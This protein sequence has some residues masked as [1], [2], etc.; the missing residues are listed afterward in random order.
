M[1]FNSNKKYV[2]APSAGGFQITKMSDSDGDFYRASFSNS[3]STSNSWYWI[4]YK[5]YAFTAGSNYRIRAKFRIIE[6]ENVDSLGLRHA[7]VS[8]DYWTSDLK[9]V[10][11]ISSSLNTW[12]EYS[13][14]RVINSS[15]TNSSG[16]SYDASQIG[17]AHV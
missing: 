8:N 5:N 15:Y 7:A 1:T 10:N 11:V 17:R 3:F 4:A 9:V 2:E 12:K 14:D 6:N 16:T 13:L